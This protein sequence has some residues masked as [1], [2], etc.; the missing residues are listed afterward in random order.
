MSCV[1]RAC[2]CGPLVPACT[3]QHERVTSKPVVVYLN[4]ESS[5]APR[6]N[7]SANCKLLTLEKNTGKPVPHL[8]GP[9][10]S[11]TLPQLDCGVSLGEADLRGG[12]QRKVSEF[13]TYS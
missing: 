7:G 1:A 6:T 12:D 4:F 10:A 3:W 11:A 5:L 9:A 13:K 8:A 2:P